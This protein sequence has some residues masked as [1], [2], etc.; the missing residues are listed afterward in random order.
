MSEKRTLS[1]S[2]SQWLRRQ[3]VYEA[4]EPKTGTKHWRESL[5][6]D[7]E[8]PAVAPLPAR[9]PVGRAPLQ[10][11]HLALMAPAGAALFGLGW[12]MGSGSLAAVQ[13]ARISPLV[14]MA[15]AVLGSA[16]VLAWR[17]LAFMGRR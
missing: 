8:H 16:G 9:E 17:G 13:M 5:L 14:W 11:H 2:V 15:V 12:L 6:A 3:D 1:Q 10:W 7:F 4:A